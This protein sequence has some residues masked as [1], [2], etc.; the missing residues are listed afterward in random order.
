MDTNIQKDLVLSINEYAFVLDETKGHVSCLVGPTKMSLS[1]SDKLVIFDS[2][3]KQ[4]IPCSTMDRAKSLFTTAPEGWYVILKNPMTDNRHPQTG[5][6]N[7][8]PDNMQIGKKIN[9]T[10]PVSFALY[11]GQMAKVVKGHALRSNQ[12]LLARVY[13]A[14]AANNNQGEILDTDGKKVETTENYIN[15][16]ILV[17]KGTEISFYIPPTGIEVIPINNDHK[18]GYVRDAVTLERLEYCILKD[19]N[20]SKRYLHGPQ[21]V[22]PKPTETFVQSAKGSVIFKAIEL[23]KISG[24][25]IK[26]IADYVDENNKSHSTGEEMFITGNEQMIYYPRPEHAIISYDNKIVHHAIAIPKGEGRYLM[27][28]LTG[29]I[30]TVVGPAMLLPDPRTEVIVKRKLTPKQA[31]LWYPGNKEVLNYNINLSEQS[32]EKSLKSL[33]ID[34][35]NTYNTTACS[36]SV[37]TNRGGTLDAYYSTDPY[38]MDALASKA[39]VSRG[40]SYTKPRTITLDNKLDGVVTVEV[41]TGYAVNVVSKNGDRRVVCGPQTVMLNYD[42]TLE[43]VKDYHGIETVFLPHKNIVVKDNVSIETKDFVKAN[44]EINYN[45]SF[46]SALQDFWFDICDFTKCLKDKMRSILRQSLEFYTIQQ[47]YQNYSNIIRDTFADTEINFDNGMIIDN[48]DVLDFTIE[49][50]EIAE[51]LE[52]H[53]VDIVKKELELIDGDKILEMSLKEKDINEKVL[54][55]K[56]ETALLKIELKKKEDEAYR[57]AEAIKQRAAELEASLQNQAILAQKDTLAQI[58]EAERTQIKLRQDMEIEHR[59]KLAAIET[60]KKKEHAEMIAHIMESIGPDL[61][62][63]LNAKSNADMTVAIAEALGPY[64]LAGEGESA[65]DVVNK[66]LRGTSLENFINM[67]VND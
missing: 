56:N 2:V 46:N 6:S 11:P 25:Y 4:F 7:S 64:A 61:V 43:V 9:I 1:Q 34:E 49:S 10:G 63:A 21:V 20:G 44:I 19:E 38:A 8:L 36:N 58:G 54:K 33:A 29:D 26:V 55:L 51:M 24:I 62:A 53:Q 42:E 5:T 39:T 17:I 32:V 35:I 30:K 60:Q 67:E 18:Q 14:A 47:L 23:S 41:W 50:D 12:Y 52:E 57:E 16:Q 3:S 45:F 15:G 48:I 31:S 59:N 65:T 37:M 27:N 22:F 28:R 40:T 13:E 66:I